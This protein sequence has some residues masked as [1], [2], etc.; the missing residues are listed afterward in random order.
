[1]IHIARFR[2][3]KYATQTDNGNARIPELITIGEQKEVLEKC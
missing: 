3:L 2:L 1:M